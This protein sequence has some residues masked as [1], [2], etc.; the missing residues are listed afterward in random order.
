LP[1]TDPTRATPPRWR[2]ARPEPFPVR[3]AASCLV[4]LA[5]LLVV[6]ALSRDAGGAEA[7]KSGDLP[8]LDGVVAA[9]G[10]IG[11]VAMGAMVVGMLLSGAVP[12]GPAAIPLRRL[13][14]MVAVFAA[15]WLV[16]STV[17]TAEEAPPEDDEAQAGEPGGPEAA[18]GDDGLPSGPVLLAAVTVM[19]LG[20]VVL[21]RVLRRTD[22][23][24]DAS[25][26]DGGEDGDEDGEVPSGDD[27]R[28][29]ATGLDDLIEQLRGDPD[30][31]HAVIRAWAGLEDLLAGHR[32]PRRPSEAPTTYVGRVLERL[33]ASRSAVDALTATF[34][35]AMFSPHAISRA[36]QLAAVDALVAVRDDLGAPV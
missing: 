28:R 20:G 11:F 27:R 4:G 29:V 26:E 24:I 31:R 30:A 10:V 21:A 22:D 14:A 35:R 17:P 36:D 19:A 23:E 5:L 18:G 6:A 32:L 16:L 15:L 1:G 9:F 33:S 8:S 7:T 12:R 25:D 34:E 3:V 2:S 13:L